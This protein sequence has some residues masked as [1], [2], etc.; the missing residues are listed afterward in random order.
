MPE[1][2]V[3]CKEIGYSKGAKEIFLN[4]HFGSRRNSQ[5]LLDELQCEGDLIAQ[6]SASFSHGNL[7]LLQEVKKVC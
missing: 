2:N 5:I 6:K 3:I 7:Q 1:A 4:S